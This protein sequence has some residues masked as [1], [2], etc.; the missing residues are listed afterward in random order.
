MGFAD[1]MCFVAA[2]LCQ[3]EEKQCTTRNDVMAVPQSDP[4]MTHSAGGYVQRNTELKSL[5]SRPQHYANT[6]T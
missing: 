3:R 6:V 4:G 1:Y 5:F 2:W